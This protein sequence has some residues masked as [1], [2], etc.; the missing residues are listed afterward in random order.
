M[1]Q[2]KFRRKIYAYL[3]VMS[4]APLLVDF[5]LFLFAADPFG[6]LSHEQTAAI[7]YVGIS[8]SAVLLLLGLALT[9]IFASKFLGPAKALQDKFTSVFSKE[10]MDAIQRVSH[11]DMELVKNSIDYFCNKTAESNNTERVAAQAAASM[12]NSN[13]IFILYRDDTDN[14]NFY[15]PEYWQKTYGTI[16]IKPHDRLEN[17]IAEENLPMLRNSLLMVKSKADRRFGIAVRMK[18]NQRSTIWVNIRCCSI[19]GENDKIVVMGTIIDVDVKRQLEAEI[20]EKYNMYKFVLASVPDI[21]YEVDVPTGKFTLLNP[22]A[23]YDMFDVDID[24]G[25]FESARRPFWEKIHRDYREGFLDRFLRYDH[26]LLLPNKSLTYEYRVLSKNNDWI[27]VEHSVKV[28]RQSEDGKPLKVIG[29][30]CNINERKRREFK[31]LYQSDHDALTGTYLR[32][33]IRRKFEMLAADKNHPV[34]INVDVKGFRHINEQYGAEIGDQVLRTVASVLWSCQKENCSVARV[35]SDDFIIFVSDRNCLEIE[36]MEKVCEKI[37][38]SFAEPIRI[39]NRTVNVAV[40]VGIAFCGEDGETFDDVYTCAQAATEYSA[41]RGD[42][43]YTFYTDDMAS[44][45]KA[46][47]PLEDDKYDSNEMLTAIHN[48]TR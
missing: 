4:G 25:D 48:T 5:I 42:N 35:G 18:V 7:L 15:I 19:A 1:K 6:L 44:L 33:A 20:N 39:Q 8:V 21:V 30:I 29:R 32:S 41:Q 36:R 24:S 16:E 28:V 23:W 2:N 43:R 31:R 13:D 38:D 40:A 37:V 46:P 45:K 11:D 14:F 27:W 22:E 12:S 10:E 47:P 34:I 26:I 3:T 9:Q 17:Y